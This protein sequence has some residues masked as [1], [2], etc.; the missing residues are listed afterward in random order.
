[1][2]VT[3]VVCPGIILGALLLY[4]ILVALWATGKLKLPDE[5]P[6]GIDAPGR[7]RNR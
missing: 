2:A 6:G 5:G 4:F 1:M 7:F 3:E